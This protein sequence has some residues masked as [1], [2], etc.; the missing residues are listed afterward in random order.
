MAIGASTGTWPVATRWRKSRSVTMPSPAPVRTSAHDSPAA[1]IRAATL[2]TRSP[3]SHQ[4]IGRARRATGRSG[5]RGPATRVNRS[6]SGRARNVRGSGIRRQT[7]S[8][9]ARTRTGGGSSDNSQTWPNVS[10]GPNRST[11]RPRSTTSS[12][13]VRTIHRWVSGSPSGTT[14]APAANNSISTCATSRARSSAS[15]ASKGA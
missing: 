3:S 9:Y 10:P 15:N 2:P 7:L 1:P 8:S 14:V 13:P 4:T 5:R 11:T 12:A 6:R